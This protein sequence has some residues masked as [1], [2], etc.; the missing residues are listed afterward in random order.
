MP[1]ERKSPS[2]LKNNAGYKEWYGFDDTEVN[3]N[4]SGVT[5]SHCF[6]KITCGFEMSDESIYDNMAY[7]IKKINNLN[8]NLSGYQ[9]GEMNGRNPFDTEIIFD[10]DI[11]Y[12][13]DLC[14]Y[15]NY[16]AIERPIQQ[17]LHRFNTAQRESFLSASNNVFSR[18]NFIVIYFNNKWRFKIFLFKNTYK[19]IFSNSF[20]VKEK[21]YN[22]FIT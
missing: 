13:G 14:C 6:G 10:K 12:Y 21:I 16:N 22:I 15:D 7:N 1:I 5:F 20:S 8:G 19:N 9:T 17:I 4:D 2:I 3:I 11:N 18:F